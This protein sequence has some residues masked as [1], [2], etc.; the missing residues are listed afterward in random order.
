MANQIYEEVPVEK[1]RWRCDPNSFPMETTEAIE[2]CQEIIGQERALEAI[3]VGLEIESIG[4]N[5]FV[6]G[7]AGTGR[8]TTIKA[9][10]EEMDVKG[11]IPNDL[12]YVNNF[13]NP[14]MPHMLSLPAGQ[15]NGFKKEMETL[16]EALKKKVPLIFENENYLNKKKEL[17]EGFRSRQ[18]EM[19]REFEKKVNK[20]GFALVQIQMG[21]YSRP[22]IFPVV[23]GNPVNIEQL[24]TMVEENKFSREEIERIKGKQAELVSELEDIF[25]ETRKSEK[26]IKDELSALDTQM[27]SPAVKDSITDI[28][29]RFNYER[30]HHYLDGVQE[31]IVANF[32]RFRE[33]EES[34]PSPI[35]G[36]VLSQPADTFAEYQVNVLVDNS[37]TKGAPIIVEMTPNYRNLFGTIERVVDRSGVWKTDFTHIKAGSF[38]RANGGYLVFNALDGLVEPGVWPALKRTLKNQVMEVQTFDPFYFFATTALKPEPI[39]CNTKIIMIGDTHLYHLLFNMDD[40]FKKIFK[41]KADFDSVTGKDEDKIRQYASFIRK[42]CDEEKLRPFDR[43]GVAAVVEHGVRIAGRQKKLSTRFHL[44]ADLLREANYWAGKDGSP[45]VKEAHVDK[46]IEKRAYRLNLVE[47]KIQE[48]ID[49]GTILIDS[50]GMVAGQ[51]NGLS[52]YNLGDYAF[53][54]PSRITVKTSLGKAGIINIEREVE[55]SGPIHNKGVYILS[56]YLRDRYAQDKP[57]T[58]S[59]SICF[60]QSYSGVEGDSAS[61]TELYGL[62]SSLSGLPLRQD[63]AVTGS[64][65]QKG[66][67]QPIGGVNEKIEGFFEVCKA[68]GLTGKQGVMIPH[69]NIDDLMLRKG[70]VQAVQEGKFRVYPV[71]TIDQGIAILTGVEAGERLED[72]RFK[73]GTVNDLVDRK[74]QEL[75]KKIKE[76]EGGGEEAKEKKKKKGKASCNG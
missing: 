68:K 69:L 11:K 76:Y 14:D 54:K 5:I 3:R 26:E 12:C 38:L 28:K 16:I 73:E 48:M 17:V 19:F 33:K 43:T 50:D 23:E 63:I 44:I 41:I 36:L 58:M 20:E 75:G 37:E 57:I 49:D 22:G 45:V 29:E 71:K 18:A 65:N 74:L 60:E 32:H 31:D 13:K 72:G 27:I 10:F 25:K 24:E 39:E 64:V 4:Y 59:A 62:L 51:V 40:D 56:G 47:E 8:F 42:V 7:L 2:P 9:V 1:L 61:S 15:G 66:E 35:P 55:M 46:A 52:V 67:V 30:I 21:P 6:T 53:G 34:P 70:V